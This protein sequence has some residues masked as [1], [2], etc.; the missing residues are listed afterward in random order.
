MKRSLVLG[1]IVV[2]LLAHLLPPGSFLAGG[3]PV[4]P[5]PAHAGLF[6][7]DGFDEPLVIDF[8]GVV[9]VPDAF[10]APIHMALAGANPAPT[11]ARRLT[12]SVMEREGALAHFVLVPTAVVESGWKLPLL[13]EEIVDVIARRDDEGSWQAEVVTIAALAPVRQAAPTEPL[14]PAAAYLFPWSGGH[15]WIKLGYPGWHGRNAVD[16]KP[17]DP[18]DL[19][20]LAAGSGTLSQVCNDGYQSIL[21]IDHGSSTT[22]YIHMDAGTI[23]TG[24]LLQSVEQGQHLGRLYTGN[25]FEDGYCYDYPDLQFNTRCGCGTVTHLHFEASDTGMLIDGYNYTDVAYSSMGTRYLSHN[26]TPFSPYPDARFLS[27]SGVATTMI[28][29][30]VYDVSITLQNVGSETWTSAYRLA[31]RNPAD[32]VLWNRARVYFAEG[33]TVAPGE[34]KRFTFAVTAP[35]QPGRYDF[36]WR[37]FDPDGGGIGEHTPSVS[38]EVVHATPHGYLE[39]PGE[40]TFSGMAPVRGWTAVDGNSVERIELWV[41]GQHQ[42]DAVYGAA[43]PDAGGNYGFNWQWDTAGLTPGT[44]TI[45]AR[46]VAGS[47]ESAWLPLAGGGLPPVTVTVDALP[48][49]QVLFPAPHAILSGTVPITGRVTVAGS[50]IDRVELYVDDRFQGL[51]TYAGDTFSWAWDTT[52]AGSGQHAV[53]VR[54]VAETGAVRWLP[55]A[56]TQLSPLPVTVAVGNRPGDATGDG[57]VDGLDYAVWLDHLH[58]TTADGPASGDFN[59]DGQV[60]DQDHAV[61]LENYDR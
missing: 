27:Q 47:G 43:R 59:G 50:V 56:A 8:A 29:G 52:R 57:R 38:I 6:E 33:E 46:T 60:D 26:G 49:G 37:L 61:W 13:D 4:S 40:G 18:A 24:L 39:E 21:R 32:N 22:R 20:I 9:P 12:V 54:A 11:R 3:D 1:F 34:S 53:R 5:P 23:P 10:R 16:F 44:H 45:Q 48:E 25:A 35:E 55:A 15:E 17:S 51:A 41:D 31:S 28:A 36:Q 42:G 58:A 30:K 2:G 14:A 19:D 7:S